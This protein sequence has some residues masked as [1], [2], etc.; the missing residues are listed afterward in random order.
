MVS[1][2]YQNKSEAFIRFKTVDKL[3]GLLDNPVDATMG[4]FTNKAMRFSNIMFLSGSGASSLTDI[5][6][7][8]STL[9]VL[10]IPFEK[11]HDV[12]LRSYAQGIKNRFKG[13]KR[14]VCKHTTTS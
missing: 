14:V 3:T 11:Y 6:N 8:I 5:P 7:A 10:G 2:Y 12:F 1:G 13:N 4:S 9:D